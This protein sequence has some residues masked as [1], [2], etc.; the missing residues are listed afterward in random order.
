[1]FAPRIRATTNRLQQ[2]LVRR[3]AST[4]SSLGSS[5][6]VPP[7]RPSYF[8]RQTLYPFLLLSTITS[9]ALNL[10]H[11]RSQRQQET[12]Q[13]SAQITVLEA[14]VQRLQTRSWTQL[15]EEEKETVERELELV[16][17]GR[18][19]GKAKIEHDEAEETSWG[20]V[21]FGK[22]G[23][24]YE[25]EKDDTDWE[26]VFKDAD[27]AELTKQAAGGSAEEL[28]PSP[29]APAV[30]APSTPPPA[31]APAPRKPRPASAQDGIYL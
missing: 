18:G 17:L 15:T 19:K 7:P 30:P 13:L 21:L 16:G 12:S 10:S 11:S 23:K 9:L 2:R 31:P 28:V 14:L 26:K 20:E 8:S 27:A 4:T 22:K 29:T 6:Q 1:M 25:P 24:A 5:S 3:S